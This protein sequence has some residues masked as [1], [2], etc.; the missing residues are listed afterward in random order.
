[1]SS[2]NPGPN[3]PA[4][5]AEIA[6]LRA[7]RAG[8]AAEKARVAQLAAMDPDDLDRKMRLAGYGIDPEPPTLLQMI[9]DYLQ[10]VNIGGACYVEVY[11]E[12]SRRRIAARKEAARRAALE[13]VV[14]APAEV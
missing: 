3:H 7:V 11:A 1:M 8:A 4:T 9:N 10:L 12:R 6:H 5:L 2:H 14:A 13:E